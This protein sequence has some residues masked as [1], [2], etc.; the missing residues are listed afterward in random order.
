MKPSIRTSFT[1][2]KK[3]H[4]TKSRRKELAAPGA[5]EARAQRL[6]VQAPGLQE[7]PGAVRFGAGGPRARLGLA[8]FFFFFAEVAGPTAKKGHQ[9]FLVG[10]FPLASLTKVMKTKGG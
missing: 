6:R 2:N 5:A 10:F 4:A 7:G 9:G 1:S 3:R 8:V